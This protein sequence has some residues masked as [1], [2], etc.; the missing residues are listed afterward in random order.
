MKLRSAILG[1]VVLLGAGRAQADVTRLR[2]SI[3]ELPRQDKPI[4]IAP[5]DAALPN[6]ARE[7]VPVPKTW[8]EQPEQ[9]ETIEGA[10]C[11]D[12]R[13]GSVGTIYSGMTS[14]QRIW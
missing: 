3:A 5:K 4:E 1:L 10:R 14:T 13:K 7:L 8:R 9:G 2:I 12:D 6:G 11:T